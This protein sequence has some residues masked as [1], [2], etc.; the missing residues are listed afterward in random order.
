VDIQQS[1]V[2]TGCGPVKSGFPITH[3]PILATVVFTVDSITV[4][5]DQPWTGPTL[6]ACRVNQRQGVISDENR[7]SIASM[8][9]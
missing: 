4:N 3:L 2:V 7:W 9:M 6:G 1:L 5:W 8:L